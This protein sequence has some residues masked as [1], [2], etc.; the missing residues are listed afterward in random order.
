MKKVKGK[1]DLVRTDKTGIISND[2][3]F[4]FQHIKASVE[5][6]ILQWKKSD[7]TVR[8]HLEYEVKSVFQFKSKSQLGYLYAEVLPKI[9]KYMTEMGD[10]RHDEVKKTDLK[11][12]SD[13]CFFDVEVNH[14]TDD[15]Y[16]KPKSLAKSSKEE[17]I[18]FI[19]KLIRLAGDM[20]IEIETP[21]DYKKRKGIKEFTR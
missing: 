17:V 6:A 13:I 20:G 4:E 7:D 8:I 1:V 11:M 19:D 14:F 15:I 12:H 10:D 18:E 21:E 5:E 3:C 2:W 9:Y 16:H